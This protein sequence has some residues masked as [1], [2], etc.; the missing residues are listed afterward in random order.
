MR[1]SDPRLTANIY[2]DAT[3]LPTFEAIQ[4]IP[5]Q[6]ENAANPA[7]NVEKSTSKNTHK[8]T[9]NHTV[10]SSQTGFSTNLLQTQT[11]SVIESINPAQAASEKGYGHLPTTFVKNSD[12]QELERATGLEELAE[13]VQ[14]SDRE[15]VAHDYKNGR[16]AN[17]L[18]GNFAN[19]SKMVEVAGVEPASRKPLQVISTNLATYLRF[20]LGTLRGALPLCYLPVYTTFA[21]GDPMPWT[22]QHASLLPLGWRGRGNVV[23]QLGRESIF[24]CAF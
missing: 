4:V 5:W 18:Q 23:A 3:Q 11:V 12:Y 16:A 14:Y 20:A 10:I 2:T 15:R 17:S 7:H 6:G 21:P 8:Y 24:F 19:D 9:H 22:C 13:N 1:H